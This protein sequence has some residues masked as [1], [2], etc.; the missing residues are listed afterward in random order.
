MMSYIAI[1]RKQLD[2]LYR[3]AMRN[4]EMNVAHGAATGIPWGEPKPE[5][6]APPAEHGQVCAYC[7]LEIIPASAL[8]EHQHGD[9]WGRAHQ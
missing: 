8:G 6:K 4:W 5:P 2:D 9:C 3:V 1:N 7:H